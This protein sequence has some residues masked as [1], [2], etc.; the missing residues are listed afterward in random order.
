M[1][2][3]VPH[4]GSMAAYALADLGDENTIS[5]AQNESAFPASPKA[6]AAGQAAMAD[7][8][9]Y[10]D[11]EWPELR[12]AIAEVHGL[13]PAQILCGAGSMELIGCLIRAYAGPGDRVLGTDYGYA[14]VASAAAQVQ[15]DYVKAREVDLTVSVDDIL[16]ALTPS[17]RIIF[18]C[19][20]GNPT[21]TLIPNSDITRLRDRLPADVL[22]VV[23][24]AYAEFCD[25][26]HDPTEIFTLANRG[27]TVI[28]R[29]FSKAYGLAGARVGWGY[30]P[31]EI[32]GELRKLLN[33]NNIS[34]AAQAAAAAAM[35]D[36][37]HMQNVVAQTA[38]IRDGFAEGCRALGLT[39][40]A[41][42][43]NFVLIRF[44]SAKQAQSADAALRAD[45]LLMRG[46]GGYGLSDCLRAT[47][48][49]GPIMDRC[50]TALE[51][52]SR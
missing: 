37:A 44:S 17:T 27:D 7:L 41:S 39:V 1:I 42:H 49:T 23:D 48:C 52:V 47:I 29:T 6:I 19:N 28:M 15:A 36:Q 12:A 13:N 51:G 2:R 9:L 40:P 10:P 11:P 38:E 26:T 35:R 50:L 16:N 43:T 5:L 32:A 18:V 45:N 21:G 34:I 24:Q 22:L 14:F 25:H 20:P 30:F 31:P 33:P 3:P 4:V 46:M 8:P